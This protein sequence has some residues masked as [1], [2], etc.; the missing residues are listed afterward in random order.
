[1]NVTGKDFETVRITGRRTKMIKHSQI[2]VK[3]SGTLQYLNVHVTVA[4]N[5]IHGNG[6]CSKIE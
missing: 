1:M 3:F 2:D 6:K 5:T 4:V